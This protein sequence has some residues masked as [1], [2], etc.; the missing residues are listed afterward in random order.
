VVI[1]GPDYREERKLWVEDR[2]HTFTFNLPSKPK[3]V[4][5]DPEFKAFKALALDLPP[6]ELLG[7]ATGCPHLYPRVLAVRELA[8]KASPV[9]W[10]S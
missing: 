5:V 10:T 3:A 2:Q 6:D 1:V 9:T 8:K 7:I 4:C